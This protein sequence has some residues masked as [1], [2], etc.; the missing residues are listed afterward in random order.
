MSQKQV[1]ALIAE[2]P[3]GRACTPEEVASLVSYLCSEQAKY[4]NGSVFVMDGGLT[5]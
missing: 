3:T 4:V 1:E 5:A 2:T